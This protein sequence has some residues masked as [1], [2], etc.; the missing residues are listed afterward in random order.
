MKQNT[1]IEW[2]LQENFLSI[3]PAEN[4]LFAIRRLSGSVVMDGKEYVLTENGFLFENGV[5]WNW[6]VREVEGELEVVAVLRNEGAEK[7]RIGNWNVLHGKSAFGSQIDLGETPESIHF[8]RW[9]PWS[10]RVERFDADKTV[11]STTLCHLSEPASKRT[12]LISFVTVD[13]MSC[14]H[15]L[16]YAASSRAITE[17]RATCDA[18]DFGLEPGKELHSETLRIKY[19]ADPYEALES[20]ADEVNRRYRPSFE[21]TAGVCWGGSIWRDGFTSKTEDWSVI[22]PA[23]VQAVQEKLGGFGEYLMYGGTHDILKGGLPGNWLKFEKRRDGGSYEDL[24]KDLHD[25]QWNFKFWFSPFWFFGEAEGILEENKD[26]LLMNKDGEPITEI[27]HRGWEFGRGPYSSELLT[28]YYLDGTHPKTK[29][30]IR[31]VFTR[32]RELGARAYMLDF[33]SIIPGAVRY[34]ESLLPIQASRDIFRAIREAAGN[35]THLQT[36]V[37]SAPAFIGC[38]NSARVVRDFGEGR[39]MH[40]YPNWRNAT[41]CMHDEH[42][43]NVHSFVQNAAAAWFT[44]KKIYVNDLNMLTIDQPV[45][46][47]FARIATTMFGLSGDSPVLMGDDLRIMSPERLR[48]LKMCLPRT[49]GIPKPVDLFECTSAG[50]GWHIVKKQIVTPY[51]TYTLVAVFNTAPDA[52]VYRTK[53]EF[54][55]LGCDAGKNYRV[56]EFWNGEYAGT[57]RDSFPCAVPPGCCKLFRLSEARAYPWLLATDMHI[58]QGRAEVEELSFD[59]EMLTLRGV[60]RRPA[61]ETGS[62]F[63][64]MPRHLKLVNHERANTMKELI[65]MQTVISLPI[66]FDTERKPFTL[67]FECMDTDYIARPGLLPYATEQEWLTYVKDHKDTYGTRVVE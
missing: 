20:W 55:K 51:D 33:L 54:A 59:G 16:A 63:F 36:A 27:F 57:F 5:R 28:M 41:Y 12:L 60:A 50:G 21:G 58:E 15:E 10:I 2:T 31:K 1:G 56:F 52:E 11:E 38:V 14:S 13:R 61:G 25:R 9:F 24:L 23:T 42:Y 53:I 19:Y 6:R 67:Q 49:E 32:Y 65:D 26:N 44:H 3:C 4:S 46:L 47:E 34:D 22:Q 45:P 17:Y 39:P 48:M 29:E 40:P 18:C 7:V 62:L 43:A 35:D 8:F 64:L 30:Y 37:A 66:D